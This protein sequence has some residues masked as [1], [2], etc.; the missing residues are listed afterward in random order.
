MTKKLFVVSNEIKPTGL[1][2]GCDEYLSLKSYKTDL[3]YKQGRFQ[4]FCHPIKT[5]PE[6]RFD[7]RSTL[8]GL[9]G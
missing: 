2:I 9:Y 1:F 3:D 6:I 8:Q 7:A 4:S 5:P